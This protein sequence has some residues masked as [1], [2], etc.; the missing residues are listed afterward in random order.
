MVQNLNGGD[1][2]SDDATIQCDFEPQ[3]QV[4]RG[5]EKVFVRTKRW[6]LSSWKV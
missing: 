6:C 5:A 4:R 3:D 1:V 2:D